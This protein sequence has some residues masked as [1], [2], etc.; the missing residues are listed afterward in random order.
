MQ[1]EFSKGSRHAIF[2]FSGKRNEII[3]IYL[4]RPKIEKLSPWAEKPPKNQVLQTEFSKGNR[5]AILQFS[6]KKKGGEI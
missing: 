2:D 6:W 3:R 1:I 4:G 5:S